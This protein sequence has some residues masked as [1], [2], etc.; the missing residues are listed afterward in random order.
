MKSDKKMR[1]EGH[2][3]VVD[4]RIGIFEDGLILGNGDLSVSVYQ[5][6]SEIVWRF[7]KSDVWDRRHISEEDPRPLTIEELRR[8]IRDEGWCSGPCGGEITALRGTDNPERMR[9]VLRGA[10]SQ[11]YPYPMPKPVGELSLHWPGDLQGLKITQKL[12]IERGMLEIICQWKDGEQLDVECF[13]HPVLNVLVVHWHLRSFDAGP[14]QPFFRDIPIWLSLYRWADPDVREFS[15]K[16]KAKYN[17]S[18][19]DGICNEKAVPLPLPDVIDYRGGYVI[20]QKFYPDR[21]FPEGFCYWLGCITNQLGVERVD[22]GVLKEARILITSEHPQDYEELLNGWVSADRRLREEKVEYPSVKDYS[23]Y[24]VVPVT[25]SNDEGGYEGQYEKICDLLS[26]D[27]E[28]V[29]AQWKE[30]TCKSA[31]DFWSASKVEIEEKVLENVWY[32]TLHAFR[33]VYRAETTPAGLFIP[34]FLHDYS[35][36]HGDYHTNYNFQQCFWGVFTSNHL[37]LAQAYFKAMEYINYVGKKIAREYFGTRGTFIQI[38]GYPMFLE[39]DP[40]P[41]SPMGRMPYMTGWAVEIYWLYYLYSRDKRFLRERAY[42][43]IRDCA[44]FYTDFLEL[45]KD[46]LYH[47]F[48][49]SFGEEGYAGNPETN[50]DAPQTMMH[51]DWCLRIAI[52]A[53]RLLDTDYELRSEWQNCLDKLA[54]G[55]GESEWEPLPEASESRHR[56]YNFPEFRPADWHRYPHRYSFAQRWWGWIQFLPWSWLRDVRGGQFVPER[57]FSDLIRVVKRWRH[58]NGLFWPMPARFWGRLGPMTEMLGIIAPLQEMMLQSWEGIIRVFPV[59]PSGIDAEFVNLRAEGAFLVSA[60][61][62]NSRI[63]DVLIESLEGE[64][65]R[66]ENPWGDSVA[67]I[68]ADDTNELLVEEKGSILSF[69]TQKWKK[70]RMKFVCE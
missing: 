53:S 54:C 49:S 63:C 1:K 12:F 41:T 32:D 34:C 27:A 14:P 47:A 61:Y 70:Y 19:F 57:D 22:T 33:C 65:C 4:E 43:F 23:G 2:V 38:C 59:W 24:V 30:E 17:F 50:T 44:L 13:V 52:S 6:E 3:L 37:E 29:L 51:A 26:S 56:E 40:V 67:R 5:R 66:I 15:A 62:K 21:E 25:T 48:P 45:G 31:E 8:G 60:S 10:P 11:K 9:E 20:Q 16:W 46:G 36:W 18:G 35:L 42:P 68:I 58:R 39:A 55:K 28:S 64:H 7:G 69:D